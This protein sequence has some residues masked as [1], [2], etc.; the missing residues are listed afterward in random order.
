M[1]W[2]DGLCMLCI[3]AYIQGCNMVSFR[4]HMFPN[5]QLSKCQHLIFGF[6]ENNIFEQTSITYTVLD[7]RLE[8]D[9][10]TSIFP[11]Q[12]NISLSENYSWFEAVCFSPSN[13]LSAVLRLTNQRFFWTLEWKLLGGEYSFKQY[14]K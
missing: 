6:F 1:S 8:L 14:C 13:L 5:A 9:L 2:M 12:D 7:S 10:S 4:L 11:R 3:V